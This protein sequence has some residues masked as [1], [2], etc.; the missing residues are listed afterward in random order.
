LKG[1]VAS[2]HEILLLPLRHRL[3]ITFLASDFQ[4]EYIEIISVPKIKTR[5][6]IKKECYWS[7]ALT[8][9]HEEDYLIH[10]QT[11]RLIINKK[12]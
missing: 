12:I 9:F 2:V 4:R 3:S 11:Y 5:K 7:Y 8:D 6:E 10:Q 1:G